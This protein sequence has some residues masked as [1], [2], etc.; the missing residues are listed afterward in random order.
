VGRSFGWDDRTELLARVVDRLAELT[1]ITRAVHTDGD[2]GDPPAPTVR[3]GD[4][5][6]PADNPRRMSSADEVKAFFG[7]SDATGAG[8]AV[9]YTPTEPDEPASQPQD[10]PAEPMRPD[11]LDERPPLDSQQ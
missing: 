8:F 10:E 5:T 9:R 4:P 3:P 1:W 11:L 2:P 6:D 7:A